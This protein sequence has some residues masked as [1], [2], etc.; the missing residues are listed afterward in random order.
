[1]SNIL[2]VIFSDNDTFTKAQKSE[3]DTASHERRF[4]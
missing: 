3:H 2:L 4:H 1:M